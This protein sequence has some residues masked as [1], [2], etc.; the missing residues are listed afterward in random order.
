[1][2]DQ[3]R[4]LGACREA[5]VAFVSYCPL[6]RGELLDDPVVAAIAA[7]HGRTPAQIVLRWHVQQ[8]GVVAIPR[9]RD[10][11]RIAANHSVF[12]FTLGEDEMDRLSGLARA[13]GRLV[14]PETAPAWDAA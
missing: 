12:D 9:S 11:G 10:P 1:M 2:L 8:P 4:V 7:A 6:G 3:T 14:D 13:G 5:G